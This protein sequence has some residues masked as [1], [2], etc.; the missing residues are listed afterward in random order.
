MLALLGLGAAA[1]AAAAGCDL[2][3]DWRAEQNDNGL[4]SFEQGA[5][6]NVSVAYRPA[7]PAQHWQTCSGSITAGGLVT[8]ETDTGH[9][10]IATVANCSALPWNS[11]PAWCRIGSA[12]CAHA[13]PP[14][15]HPHPP[16]PPDLAIKHVHVVAMNHLDVGFS[17][18]GCGGSNS[19]DI[20]S[21]AAPYT[22]QLLD[23]YLNTAFPAAI[24][25]SSALAARSAHTSNPQHRGTP[26][27]FPERLPVSTAATPRTSTRRTAGSSPTSSTAPATSVGSA[28]LPKI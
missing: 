6:G 28:A 22:W 16:N 27:D 4:Y 18:K 26:G 15:P 17:C 10:L 8:L 13:P 25:T 9:T 20:L 19:K 7:G 24:N 5:A 12:D 21:M 11:G 14:S 3:G 1:A 23:Y 2:S